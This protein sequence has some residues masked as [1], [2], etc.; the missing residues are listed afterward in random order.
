MV[1]RCSGE[2]PLSMDTFGTRR[3]R[4]AMVLASSWRRMFSG[5]EALDWWLGGLLEGVRWKEVDDIAG[6]GESISICE[7]GCWS[8]CC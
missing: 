6:G 1:G 7:L 8:C 4:E 3:F 5:V 2:Q